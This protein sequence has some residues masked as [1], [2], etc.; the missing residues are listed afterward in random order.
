MC[1]G[2]CRE[3]PR[4]IPD[5]RSEIIVLMLI[6]VITLYKKIKVL[7]HRSLLEKYLDIIVTKSDPIDH[8]AS[9]SRCCQ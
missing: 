3:K 7:L 9:Q 2:L 5:S 1:A 4:N 6:T 8:I